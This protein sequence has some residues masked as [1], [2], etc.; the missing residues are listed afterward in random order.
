MSIFGKVL[1]LFNLLAATVFVYVAAV[2]W[3]AR[4]K[5]AYA[6]YRQDLT[7]HGLP[8]DERKEDVFDN[9]LAVEKLSDNTL[10]QVFG[11]FGE[12]VKTQIEEVARLQRRV[13]DEL[14]AVAD[15]DAKKKKW[16][17]IFAPLANNHAELDAIRKRAADP[18][19]TWSEL[20]K[21][22][23]DLFTEVQ[24]AETDDE[25]KMTVQ[26]KTERSVLISTLPRDRQRAVAHL[27]FNVHPKVDEASVEA[28]HLRLQV[29]IGVTAFN[30]E[31]KHQADVLQQ[32]AEQTALAMIG[33]RAAFEV[34]YS[35]GL[36]E[37]RDRAEAIAS[38]NLDLA[39]QRK[40]KAEHTKLKEDRENDVAKA[41]DDLGKARKAT[42]AALEQ[43]FTE[44]D[45]LFK[46]QRLVGCAKEEN[47]R[48]ERRIRSLEKAT[49]PGSKAGVKLP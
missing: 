12:P 16:L 11:S 34:D 25:G 37:V 35:A 22:T 46:A 24:T 29:V 13:N 21:E 10:R 47:E 48:L 36:N 23:A 27:L 38:R 41:K 19:V 31:A 44:E 32:M 26:P 3:A 43:Q 39:A 28:D 15:P 40:L 49:A 1:I 20:E 5:W 8:L 9:S 30:I 6:V 2:D 7:L 42:H 18:K 17:E 33:D 4:Y 45:T 14:N